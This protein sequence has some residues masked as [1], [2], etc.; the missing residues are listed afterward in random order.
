[1]K[2]SM[3]LFERSPRPSS[4]APSE[5]STNEPDRGA[6]RHEPE[7]VR[8]GSGPSAC[9]ERRECER[10]HEPGAGALQRDGAR[11]A[12][13]HALE[14][15]EEIGASSPGLADLAGDRVAARRRRAPSPWRAG[16][17]SRYGR[18]RG[19]RSPRT[20]R[21]RCSRSRCP[22]RAVRRAPRRFRAPLFRLRPIRV[23]TCRRE[24]RHEQQHPARG[25]C[26]PEHHDPDERAD[27]G[28][29]HGDRARVPPERR[30]RH[31][32][33][34]GQHQRTRQPLPCRR[35]RCGVHQPE[36]AEDDRRAR[37]APRCCRRGGP[38]AIR[39]PP[40]RPPRARARRR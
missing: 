2:F 33:R 26:E 28:A 31:V 29:A 24:E 7:R 6:D 8:R 22:G 11:R 12:R 21:G 20:R 27:D 25:A 40:R 19:Q 1:M 17:P 14:G 35:P 36:A 34:G 13:P 10:G 32:D 4:V 23:E 38:G 3:S 30:N 39:R 15:R 5:L 18:Q 37:W 9:A 16:A